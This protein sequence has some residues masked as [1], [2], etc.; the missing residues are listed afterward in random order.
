[1]YV[2]SIH[3]SYIIKHHI[4]Y[5]VDAIH[6]YPAGL[7]TNKCTNMEKYVEHSSDY[8]RFLNSMAYIYHRES[9]K[10]VVPVALIFIVQFEILFFVM[11]C[12]TWV[13]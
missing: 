8:I 3:V 7:A 13:S 10:M 11:Q 1:M 12:S 6:Q 2:Q 4:V 9:K 5:N